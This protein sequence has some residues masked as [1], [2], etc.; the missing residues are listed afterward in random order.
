MK[1]KI[2]IPK[3]IYVATKNIN[4]HCIKGTKLS[5]EIEEKEKIIIASCILWNKYL[6]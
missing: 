1:K 4:T 6:S 2:K 3:G 5:Y